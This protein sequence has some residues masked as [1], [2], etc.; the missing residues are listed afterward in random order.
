MKVSVIVPNHNRD[1]STLK[2]SLPK[3][4]EFIHVNI[5]LERSEQ[6]NIGIRASKGEG[7]L[8]LDSDQSISQG[9]ID[10]CI[11]LVSQPHVTCVYIPEIIIAKSFFGKVRKFEREFYTGTAVDV[12]RFVLKEYCPEFNEDLHGP[13]DAD[14]GN[15]IRGKRAISKNPLY[16]HDDIGIID[17]FK[18]KAY[19]AKSMKKF[20]DRN[21][22]DPVLKLKYRC[23]T[24][25][26]ENGKWKKLLRHPILS[27]CIFLMIIA[28]GVIYVK[29]VGFNRNSNI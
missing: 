2:A 14:W 25:F 29:A 27:F 21:P 7:L 5:G 15:R 10:E 13:E 9:L 12:P 28:R 1:I 16:H 23:W 22:I 6:R 24:V 26:T 11:Q 17:Y 20:R 4:V 18:K 8:I 19:Y 3:Y